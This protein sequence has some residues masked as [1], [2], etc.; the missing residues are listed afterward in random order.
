M[1][2]R[3]YACRRLGLI[4]KEPNPL[5]ARLNILKLTDKARAKHSRIQKTVL[6][7]E[8]TIESQIGTATLKEFVSHLSM[9]LELEF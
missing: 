9:F 4:T 7:L 5:D 1:S 8:K 2:G 6:D 3:M